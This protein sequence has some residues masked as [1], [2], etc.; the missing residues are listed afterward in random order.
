M[1]RRIDNPDGMFPR[2]KIPLGEVT[3]ADYKWMQQTIDIM[4]NLDARIEWLVRVIKP[5]VGELTPEGN[6]VD[7]ATRD[8]R[9]ATARELYFKIRDLGALIKSGDIRNAVLWGIDI[10]ALGQRL[11]V[12]RYEQ[13]VIHATKVERG[14]GKGRATKARATEARQKE[15]ADA[16][17]MR[18]KIYPRD[19]LTY[20]RAIVADQLKISFRT[21]RTATASLKKPREKMK[22]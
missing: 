15:I 7:P 21:V 5:L 8:D 17:K 2:E 12:L 1:G 16:V 14:L 22:K 3:D 18:M 13:K 20:A 9:Q 10:G 6:L 19:T 4:C 11:D